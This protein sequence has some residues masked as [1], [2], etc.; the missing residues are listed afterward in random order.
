MLLNPRFQLTGFHAGELEA[1]R[2]AGELA[3]QKAQQISSLFS[4]R[5]ISEQLQAFFG[6]LTL[7]YTA[8]RWVLEVWH[9]GAMVLVSSGVFNELCALRMF[10]W[11][12][13]AG[14]RMVVCGPLCCT[15]S[16]SSFKFQIPTKQLSVH[17]SSSR[18]TQLLTLLVTPL[19]Q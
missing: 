2:R 7:L 16:K 6:D 10:Q 17:C 13:F 14:A 8:V 1:Q 18:V 11:R 15:D 4:T 3:Q 12:G 5:P 9:H 19:G